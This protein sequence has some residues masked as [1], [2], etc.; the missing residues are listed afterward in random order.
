LT[1]SKKCGIL[2]PSFKTNRRKKMSKF[3]VAT[4]DQGNGLYCR[5]V[6]YHSTTVYSD[7]VIA[8]FDSQEETNSFIDE[9]EEEYI[10]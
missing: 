9:F 8:E 2:Y 6:Q 4:M 1:L 7:R 5:E 10:Y 3:V